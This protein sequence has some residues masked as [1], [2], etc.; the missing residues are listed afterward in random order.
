R[1]W[2][3]AGQA[4]ARS[5][6]DDA[7]VVRTPADQSQSGH[8]RPKLRAGSRKHALGS[9]RADED[10][11]S[12]VTDLLAK[13]SLFANLPA[14]TMATVAQQM[15]PVSYTNGQQIFSRGDAG[16]E[17]YLLLEGRV[18]LSIISLDGRELAFTHAGPGDIFG[19]IATLDGGARTADAT[20]VASS[21][22]LTLS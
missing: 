12:T 13:N 11:M 4:R 3:R 5:A 17:L 9:A 1:Y 10:S 20:A 19:E 16:T 22:G 14:D 8:L 6:L 2:P 18:R 15:R 7:S 21:K